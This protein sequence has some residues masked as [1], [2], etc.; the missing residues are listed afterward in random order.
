MSQNERALALIRY[1]EVLLL[2]PKDSTFVAK[3]V[4]ATIS[5]INKELGIEII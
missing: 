5:E 2:V 4:R 1:L 3:E